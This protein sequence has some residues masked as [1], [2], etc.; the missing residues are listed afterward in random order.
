[1][2][3][4]QKVLVSERALIQRINRKLNA[5]DQKL[6]A[7]RGFWDRQRNLHYDDTNVGRFYVVDLLRNFVVDSHIDLAQYAR[8][9]GAMAS[10]EELAP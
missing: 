2:K 3:K 10:W 4:Q 1:M 6:K 9:L 8:K 7:A 5:E